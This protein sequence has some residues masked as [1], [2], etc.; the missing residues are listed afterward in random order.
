MINEKNIKE[1]AKSFNSVTISMD[2]INP[3]THDKLRGVEGVYERA[4]EALELLRAE[5]VPIAVNMVI[6]KENFKEIDQYLQFFSQKNI[7]VQF[8]PVHDCDA[9]LLK[10]ADKEL[11]RIDMK[12]FRKEWCTLAEKYSFFNNDYY[13]HVPTFFSTPDKLLHAYTCFA[14]AV[15]FFVNPYGEVYPCE[16]YRKSMGNIKKESLKDIWQKGRE[17]RRFIASSKRSCVCWTHCAVPLNNRL[18]R[19]VSLKKGI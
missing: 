19:F 12:E 4:M 15:M 17:L 13:R 16:F 14:G 5:K 8:T 9:N 11:K 7:A 1:V 18:T 10:V 2:G 6:T 3:K